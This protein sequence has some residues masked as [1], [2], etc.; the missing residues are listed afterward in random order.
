MAIVRIQNAKVTRINNNGYGVQVKE[1][2]REVSGRTFYGK[3]FTLWF[4]EPHGLSEGATVSV[5]GFLD[6]KVDEWTDRDGHPRQ[7]VSFS[8]NSQKIDGDTRQQDPA[9]SGVPVVEAWGAREITDEV[10]F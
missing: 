7:S 9:P 2:D 3:R 8:V 6:A 4:K 10:P 1:D 5:S